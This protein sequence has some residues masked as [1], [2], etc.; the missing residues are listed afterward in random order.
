LSISIS[1]TSVLASLQCEAKRP[2][3][4]SFLLL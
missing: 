3:S 2:P 1:V 4:S